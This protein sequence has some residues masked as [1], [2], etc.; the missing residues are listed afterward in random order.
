VSIPRFPSQPHLLGTIAGAT[1]PQASAG[2]RLLASA[3]TE[4]RLM[5]LQRKIAFPLLVIAGNEGTTGKFVA[6]TVRASRSAQRR[7]S[8]SLGESFRW[9]DTDA[10]ESRESATLIFRQRWSELDGQCSSRVSNRNRCDLWQTALD[11]PSYTPG[12]RLSN[13]RGF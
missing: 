10:R 11:G 8:A 2:R 5:S 7:R 3:T 1:T 6:T 13:C 4:H 9:T 12:L